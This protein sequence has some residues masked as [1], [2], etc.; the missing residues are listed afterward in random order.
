MYLIIFW[1]YIYI[2]LTF[3]RAFAVSQNNHFAWFFTDHTHFT[4]YFA[5]QENSTDIF[6][7]R[8]I[9]SCYLCF[10]YFSHGVSHHSLWNTTRERGARFTGIS[11]DYFTYHFTSLWNKM[12]KPMWKLCEIPVKNSRFSHELHIYFT[13]LV[14]VVCVA[15]LNWFKC[16]SSF[17]TYMLLSQ[18]RT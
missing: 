11:H 10:T 5:W 18:K 4:W 9:Y 8:L 12:W 15:Y 16:I 3:L 7:G 13:G 6:T 2:S 1:Y 17:Y 14:P